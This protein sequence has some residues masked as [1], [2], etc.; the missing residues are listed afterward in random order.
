MDAKALTQRIAAARRIRPDG[1]RLDFRLLGCEVEPLLKSLRHHTGATVR[2]RRE[3]A[4][5]EARIATLETHLD[6]AMALA[7][8]GGA[9]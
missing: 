8:L 7:L 5:L 1:A 3:R 2:H 4:D 9:T 6:R